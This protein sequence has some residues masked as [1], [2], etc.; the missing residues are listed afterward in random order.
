MLASQRSKSL[1]EAVS[2]ASACHTSVGTN[3]ILDHLFNKHWRARRHQLSHQLSDLAAQP[4]ACM[5]Q[6]LHRPSTVLRLARPSALERF[7]KRDALPPSFHFFPLFSFL[8]DYLDSKF[9]TPTATTTTATTRTTTPVAVMVRI[10]GL[11]VFHCPMRKYLRRLRRKVTGEAAPATQSYMYEEGC[12]V[13]EGTQRTKVKL[14]MRAP[15]PYVAV[16]MIPSHLHEEFRY[17]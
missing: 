10:C 12:E 11:Y 9:P 4:R 6:Y 3:E 15:I 13:Y 5:L 8:Q 7:Y 16:L 1:Q 2:A 14:N 17:P